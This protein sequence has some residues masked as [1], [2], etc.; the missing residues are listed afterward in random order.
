[1]LSINDRGNAIGLLSLSRDVQGAM[2]F[3]G[4]TLGWRFEPFSTELYPTWIA[5]NPEGRSVAAF[6]DSSKSDFPDASELWLPYLVVQD[7]DTAL[8]QAEA[9]ACAGLAEDDRDISPFAHARDI[10]SVSELRQEKTSQSLTKQVVGGT[11]GAR[12]VLRAVPGLTEQWLQR[13]VDCHLARNAAL[14]HE[15]ASTEM[16]FCPLTLRAAQA[17]VSAL[18][19]G[20][21]V[22][23]RSDDPEAAKEIWQRAQ[24]LAQASQ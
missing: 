24:L 23:V 16:A 3:Y 20:F 19:S 7:L 1:M 22:D 4:G 14:G 11:T 15:A 13:I 2:L 6:V 8:V 21:A 9:G 12:I 18:D 10:A 17:R 5:R